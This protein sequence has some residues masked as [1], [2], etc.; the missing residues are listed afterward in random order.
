MHSIF[1]NFIILPTKVAISI[2]SN[3]LL[4]LPELMITNMRSLNLATACGALGQGKSGTGTRD[5]DRDF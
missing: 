3:I 2:I 1:G 5:W 4:K